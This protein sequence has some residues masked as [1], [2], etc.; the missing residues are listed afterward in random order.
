MSES[1][2]SKASKLPRRKRRAIEVAKNK[3]G[4]SPG[5]EV[6]EITT[7]E[8]AKI[9]AFIDDPSN[10]IVHLDLVGCDDEDDKAGTF[11]DRDECLK[12]A[13]WLIQA[14]RHLVYG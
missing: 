6:L 4:R 2:L 3:E 5:L 14:A 10:P 12:M 7:A 11:M 13:A 8:G 9:N 1:K